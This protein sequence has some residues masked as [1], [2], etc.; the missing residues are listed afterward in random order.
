MFVI[1]SVSLTGYGQDLERYSSSRLDNLSNQLKR[2][3]VDLVDRTDND[4]RRGSSNS[5]RDIEAAFLARQLDSSAGL[6]D[7]MVR[8]RRSAAEL[9]DGGSILGDL[10][11]RAPT[12][13][14]NTALWR[15]VQNAIND[16]NRELGRG[17]GGGNSGGNEPG[18]AVT[19]R[20]FWRGTVDDVVHLEIRGRNIDVRTISGRE[21]LNGTFSF[22]SP[23]P[24]RGV[25]VGV[26]KKRGRGNVEVIQQPSRTNDYT[27]VVRITDREGG[28]REYQ[29]EI[30]W[31]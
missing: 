2:Y 23:L 22:T 28:A 3:T 18:G 4:L 31:Q 17:T 25:S 10:A 9:R 6:F 16:I 20:A 30:F 29:L 21:Y 8:D 24:T 27:T 5:R 15:D 11:R 1:L 14:S 12:F 13:G 19:G 26:E 7:E